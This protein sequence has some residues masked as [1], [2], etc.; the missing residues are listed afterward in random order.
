MT[1]IPLTSLA[2]A[3][4]CLT[5]IG[6]SAPARAQQPAA[7]TQLVTNGP[8]FTPG[9]DAGRAAAEQNVRESAEYGALLRTNPA[10][11]AIRIKKEC[12]PI[13]DPE[14]R[15]SCIGS[16]PPVEY[17]AVTRRHRYYSQTARNGND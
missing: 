9:D 15:A 8:Q 11:R 13:S 12:G 5:A 14:L 3:T 6:V 17:A 16:F 1:R 7:L 10:F 2:L 4:A